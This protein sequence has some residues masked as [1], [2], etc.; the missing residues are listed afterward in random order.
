MTTTTRRLTVTKRNGEAITFETPFT[1][2]EAIAVLRTSTI[3]EP[4]MS[5]AGSLVDKFGSRRGLSHKQNAWMHKLAV[6]ASTPRDS[7][8]DR[9]LDRLRELMDRA[10]KTLEYPK[11]NLTTPDG[12]RVRLSRA[13]EQ[14]REPGV[15]HITDG[16][17][18]GENTYYGKLYT[19]GVFMPTRAATAEVIEFLEAFDADP[20][21]VAT[22][23]GRRTGNCCFCS[24]ELT[25]GRSVAVGYGAVCAGHY[26]LPWGEVRVASTVDGPGD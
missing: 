16:R 22:A 11:I 10:K 1:D 8:T 21:A 7:S 23:Y 2:D 18:F 12:K 5:F 25:D 3:N 13:G 6:D 24:R 19:D 17:P 15:V 9:R 4:T 26:D 14:S 20:E